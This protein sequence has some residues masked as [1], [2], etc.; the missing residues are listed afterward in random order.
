MA[1]HDGDLI[2]YANDLQQR[3]LF[4]ADIEGA[5]RMRPEVFTQYLIDILIDAGEIEDAMPCHISRRGIA[6]DAYGIED[7]DTLNLIGTIFRGEVPP[8]SVTRT[9]VADTFRRL[10][11]LWER[12][13]ER[14]YHEQLEESSESY[15]MALHI[16]QT[17]GSIK[18][19]H[20]FVIT[21]GL[22]GADRL[23]TGSENGLELRSSVWDVERLH[24]L[25]TSGHPREPIE[26]DFR[27]R[28]GRPL[29][30][31]TL[32]DDPADYHAMLAVLPGAWLADIYNEYGARLLELNV[33]SFLQASGK[34]NRGI[35][36]TLRDEPDRFLAYN[37]GIS[38]TASS[39][40]LVDLPDGGKGIATMRDLQIVNGGQ[41]TASIHRA[42]LPEWT[43]PLS[44][45]R[46]RSRSWRPSDSTRS[47]RSSPDTPTARTR[48]AKPTSRSNDPFHVE[49]EAL[50]RTIWT[51]ASGET[52]RQTRWFYE[53]ARGQYATPTHE[54]GR[55]LASGRG[56]MHHPLAQKFTKT[57]LAKFENAW[58][59]LPHEVS[60]G[61]QKNFTLFMTGLRDRPIKPTTDY[62]H[63]LIAK[64][65][66]WKRTER[67]VSEQNY[68]GYR[69]NL[70]AYSIAK[71]SHA[72][73][74]QLD[75]NRIWD[76]Q[77]L[78]P[79]VEQALVELSS[80]AW[81]VL[82]DEAPPERISPSGPNRSAVGAPCATNAGPCPPGWKRASSSATAHSR[83]RAAQPTM[84][85]L[86][87]SASASRP[88]IGSP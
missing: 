77:A 17:A 43:S 32:A 64:A 63:Q 69:A 6:A 23:N 9:D 74:Q 40:E 86:S 47:C 52:M 48:S 36:D 55:P 15:D 62:F 81:S 51:P 82:V 11:G 1:R 61:A 19:L 13:R 66:M 18:R 12:C 45:S 76:A 70:V 54:R 53:R 68:G 65:I 58:S 59:Q 42:A 34:V 72:T 2:A 83:R 28:F 33:R 14:P 29:P 4:E 80:L 87:L 56:E 60:R 49:V 41:T 67:L 35:R 21:D 30:C 71:L 88:R 7:G 8:P 10:L 79:A 24:R 85:Q 57:D 78:P 75:L 44:R 73:A 5:E 46:P 22:S 84:T 39:V 16:H 38:A 37:N 20:L 31:L 27:E 3:L 26:I 50:S 25:E